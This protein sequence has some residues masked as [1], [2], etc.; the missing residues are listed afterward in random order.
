MK[1]IP[2][3]LRGPLRL[4][5]ASPPDYTTGRRQWW[6]ISG[7]PEIRRRNVGRLARYR[8]QVLLTEVEEDDTAEDPSLREAARANRPIRSLEEVD[9][10]ITPSALRAAGVCGF[11]VDATL[12][13]HRRGGPS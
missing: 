12:I 9:M 11:A 10:T 13:R 2:H 6:V 1:P 7:V 5:G 8:C 3:S 4:G